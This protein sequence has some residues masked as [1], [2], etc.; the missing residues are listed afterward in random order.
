MKNKILAENSRIVIGV[1]VHTDNHVAAVKH[2]GRIIDRVKMAGTPRQWTAYLRRFP[3]CELH[4]VYEAGPNGY[5][6]RDCLQQLDGEDGRVVCVYMAPPSMIPE[7]AAKKK[8][9][10]DRRDAEKLIVAFESGGFRPIAVPSPEKRAARQLARERD[11]IK[12]DIKKI[13]NRIHGFAK[14]HG[15]DYPDAARWSETWRRGLL[16]G[17]ENKDSAGHIHF[18]L[19]MEMQALKAM[20]SLLLAV[21][22]RVA[23]LFRRGELKDLL[24][25]LMGQ[26][27]IGA[28]AASVIAT[29][30]ADFRAFDNSDAFASYTG[31][32]SG[33]RSSGKTT[34]MGPIT[35]VGNRRLRWVFVE[36]AWAWVRF[37]PAAKAKFEELKARRGAR[38]A[39]VAMARK[40]AVKVYHRV[41]NNAPADSAY[42]CLT[43]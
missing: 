38:R 2:E 9:K 37:D 41:V 18:S 29:E 10:T 39:I 8:I 26:T 7:A 36:S 32:V 40:L 35:K 25:E 12:K 31:L 34:R 11:R 23:E 27:G 6:L 5:N 28:V 3:A 1:D 21:E 17:A 19:W 15:I 33:A 16:A 14:F 43:A 4:I 24:R 22:K 13:K 42:Y 20:E 30:V